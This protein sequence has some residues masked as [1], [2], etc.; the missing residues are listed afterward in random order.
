MLHFYTLDNE[1]SEREIKKTVPF[2]TASKRIKY[3]GINLPKEAKDLYS[4][5]YK[6][7]MKEMEENTKR[8]NRFL[9]F[10]PPNLYNFVM[11]VFL[12]KLV[13]VIFSVYLFGST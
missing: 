9:L 11:A 2:T 5:N 10:K 1:R 3:L 6:M 4:Q 12:S 7:L 8:E 13:L